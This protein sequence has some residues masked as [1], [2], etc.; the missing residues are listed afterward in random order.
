MATDDRVNLDELALALGETRA[1]LRR[2]IR[3][4]LIVPEVD[5]RV[6][7]AAARSAVIAYWRDVI[8]AAEGRGNG[9]GAAKKGSGAMVRPGRA[10]GPPAAS[11]GP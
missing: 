5:G 9:P 8:A 2:F 6:R 10:A 4:G 1:G 11:V 3:A 7:L